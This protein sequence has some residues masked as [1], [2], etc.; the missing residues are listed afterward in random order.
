MVD[1]NPNGN[2][3]QFVRDLSSDEIAK[4]EKY[5]SVFTDARSRFHLFKIL[6][7]NYVE[8]TSYINLL[9]NPLTNNDE[10][11]MLQLDRLLL[12]YLSCAYTIHEH[13]KTSFR[14]RFRKNEAKL[15]EYDDFINGLCKNSWEFA[16]FLDFRG[17]VQH[18]GLGIGHFN[19]HRSYIGH[20][21]NHPRCGTT[22]SRQ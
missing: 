8:W 10:D 16:F 22:R 5:I 12:N 3:L 4:H 20:V 1:F 14:R 9:L 6:G 19:R 17:Y 7:R 13:F 18:C 21:A 2:R 15:K 11:A